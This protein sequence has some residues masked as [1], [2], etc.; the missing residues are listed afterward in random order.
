MSRW[1]RELLRCQTAGNSCVVVS[2]VS[3]R[4]SAPREAGTRML[5]TQAEVIGSIGGGNLEFKSIGIARDMLAADSEAMMRRFP[6]G[7]SLGQCCGGVVNLLFEPV[8]PSASWPGAL[9]RALD[10]G[11]SCTLATALHGDHR[12]GK[13]LLV[14]G[15]AVESLPEA[16]GVP[17][18][19]VFAGRGTCG[20]PDV[21]TVNDRTYLVETVAPSAFQLYLFGAG[22]VARALVKILGELDCHVT[23]IDSREHEFP[24]DVPANAS[25][26]VSDD[27]AE[28]VHAATPNAYFLVMTHSHTLD[29][30]I[31]ESILRRGEFTWFGLIGSQTKRRLFEAR[32]RDRG[33]S[34]ARLA[35]MICP[36]GST[37]VSS[38]EPMAIALGV[39]AQ[40]L[41]F[42]ESRKRQIP[43]APAPEVET[44]DLAAL[45]SQKAAGSRA[46]A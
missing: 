46:S 14:D 17:L 34:A 38:K 5:V 39:A 20:G 8:M 27:P 21:V 23:W 42:N 35:N 15:A 32:L 18:L 16:G 36:I 10:S 31:A 1:V 6:L 26:V 12:D 9:A 4:G 30:A 11:E 28:A 45:S 33:I 7:A 37:L 41:E 25:C 22:H 3:T 2:V 43:A 29:Q 19:E 44:Q 13:H 40:I 24:G